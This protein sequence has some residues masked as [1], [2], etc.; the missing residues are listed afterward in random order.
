MHPKN[1]I[2]GVVFHMSVGIVDNIVIAEK[3]KTRYL[4]ICAAYYIYGFFLAFLSYQL[5]DTFS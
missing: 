3:L 5:H 4:C 1:S 2:W